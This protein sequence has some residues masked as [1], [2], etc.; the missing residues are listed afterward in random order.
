MRLW[1]LHPRHLDARG[2]VALWR[3]GLLA[4]AV[5]RGRTR[6]YR[7]HPQRTA[8]SRHGYRVI[9][10]ADGVEALDQF[11]AHQGEVGLLILDVVMPR[12]SGREVYDAVKAVRPDASVLFLSGYTAEIIHKK[13]ILDEGLQF[14][15]KPLS[16]VDLLGRV[17]GILDQRK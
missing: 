9:E 14:L 8:L 5:L 1:S 2:L 13:G 10:A 7:H 3:E 4:R 6:G 11:T 16:P 12:K 15:P 17:R